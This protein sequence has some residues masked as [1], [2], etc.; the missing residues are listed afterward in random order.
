MQESKVLEKLL[1]WAEGRPEIRA[2]ILTS[3]RARADD[4]ADNLSDYDVILAVTD[5]EAFAR[6]ESW[7]N[8]YGR[9]L[10]R[11]SDQGELGDATTYFHGVVYEDHVKIDYTVWPAVLLERIAG[12][13][14]LPDALDVGYRVVLD[15]DGFTAR[16]SEPTYKAHI[17]LQPTE[18][19]YVEQVE[20]FWWSATYVAKSL[21]RGEIVFAKFVLDYDMK[22]G[23]LRRFLEWHIEIEHGWSVRPGVF[24]RG[25]ERRLPPDLWSEL[26]LTYVGSDAEDNWGAL[27]RTSALF[28]R[29]AMEVGKSLGYT[30]PQRVDDGVTAHLQAVRALP[31]RRAR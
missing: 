7:Q 4:T 1:A 13:D 25:L 23:P 26:A 30:Y 17:P 28:R 9:P 29:V 22:L 5:A 31:L 19:E 6:D 3:S 18:K 24:G 11:W 8:A 16:W 14:A 2:V 21:W 20:E 10:A 15:K 27:F 12:E